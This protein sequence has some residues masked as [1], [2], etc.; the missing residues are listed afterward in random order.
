M[1]LPYNPDVFMLSCGE[2]DEWYVFISR[3]PNL[4]GPLC[5]TPILRM[6]GLTMQCLDAILD[7]FRRLMSLRPIAGEG[8]CSETSC[9]T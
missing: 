7:S 5:Q 8:R 2:C 9:S 4:F 6:G 1:Q 3:A